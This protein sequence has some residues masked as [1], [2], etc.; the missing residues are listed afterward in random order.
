MSRAATSTRPLFSTAA[1][2]PMFT[3]IFV[4]RGTAWSF[5]MPNFCFSLGRTSFRYFSFRRAMVPRLA[6]LVAS[7]L[8]GLGLR[9]R[10]TLARRLAGLGVEQHDVARVDRALDLLALA[11][12]VLLRGLPVLPAQVDA[13]DDDAVLGAEDVLD[14]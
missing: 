11:L 5:S 1:P 6:V 10:R 12:R 3:T 4:S 9:V 13:L 8:L 7:S 2:T 14:L